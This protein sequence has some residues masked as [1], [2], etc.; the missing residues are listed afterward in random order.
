MY[1]LKFSITKNIKFK[2]EKD[3]YDGVFFH[4]LTIGFIVI[5]WCKFPTKEEYENE[6]R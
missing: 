6:N 4:L 1:N 2:H 3:F 5:S